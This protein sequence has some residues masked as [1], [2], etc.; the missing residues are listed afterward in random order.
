MKGLQL[1]IPDRDALPGS[2]VSTEM[3]R[4]MEKSR[5]IIIVLS[6][7]FLRSPHCKEQADL[8]G[9]ESFGRKYYQPHGI[10]ILVRERL[11]EE[12]IRAPFTSLLT[13]NVVDAQSSNE[14]R[15]N[16]VWQQIRNFISQPTYE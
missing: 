1:Y 7:S 12:A 9:R 13:E 15:I 11:D 2:N 5:K 6:N 4:A 3:I 14:R 16:R 8:A 10:M